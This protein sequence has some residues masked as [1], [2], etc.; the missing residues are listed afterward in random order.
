LMV[1]PSSSRVRIFCELQRR[2]VSG[3]AKHLCATGEFLCACLPICRGNRRG[4][5]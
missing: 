3:V 5:G 4:M 1:L 2:E